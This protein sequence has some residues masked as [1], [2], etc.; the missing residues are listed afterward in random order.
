MHGFSTVDGFVELNECLAE[1][2][3]YIANEP[4][5]GLYY[6]QQ[7]TQNAVPN[8]INLKNH[9]VEK[10]RETTLHTEDLED[11]IAMVGSMKECGF[12]IADEM[13]RDI[14]KSLAIMSKKQPRRGLIHNPS[15]GFHVGRSSS[16]GPS[17]WGRTAVSS[18]QNDQTKDS[19][20]STVFKSAKQKANHFKWPQLDPKELV[21]TK[22][23]KLLQKHSKSVSV[24]TASS[25]LSEPDV[26]ADELPVSSQAPNEL[27][28]E[29]EE[30]EDEKEGIEKISLPLDTIL[31]SLPENYD[32]FKA[33]KEAEL[34]EWLEGT[35]GSLNGGLRSGEDEGH[36]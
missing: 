2:I 11:S 8:V 20:F 31:P 22:G 4:S 10:S 15:S 16:W 36:P 35:G 5:V 34:E 33:N 7:H 18:R 6:V 9:V 24:T 28:E 21:Q 13:I 3:K 14:G 12:P 1:M 26:E 19:Y 17:M 27:D 25:G 30:E 23:D 29:G 32:E